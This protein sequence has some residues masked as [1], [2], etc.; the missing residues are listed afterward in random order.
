MTNYSSQGQA[1]DRVIVHAPVNERGLP[2]LVNQRFA[3]VALSRARFDAQIFTNDAGSLGEN[4]GREV[5]KSVA[6]EIQPVRRQEFS[7][8][9]REQKKEAALEQSIA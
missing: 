1:A 7:Q 3:Y 2:D 9:S 8:S 4:F 5:S 6:I